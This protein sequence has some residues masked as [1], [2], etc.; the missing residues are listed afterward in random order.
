MNNFEEFI[1]FLR[2][3]VA[4]VPD[5]M[6]EV[7]FMFATSAFV[8]LHATYRGT[9]SG[10]FGPFPPS[11]KALELS[12]LGILRVVDGKVAEIWVEW[13]SYGMLTQLGHLTPPDD[14]GTGKE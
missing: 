11:G 5:S 9:Q 10:Q 13:D 8:G 3:D 2:R 12:F 4:A 7:D 6:Q 14:P 1:A